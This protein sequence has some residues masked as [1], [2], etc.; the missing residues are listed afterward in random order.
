M[1]EQTMTIEIAL[2]NLQIICDNFVGKKQDHIALDQAMNTI[3][4]ALK[5]N[6]KIPGPPST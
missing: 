2:Q 1:P 6:I 5:Q 4:E 3:R